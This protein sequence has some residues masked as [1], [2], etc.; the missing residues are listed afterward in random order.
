LRGE[1][2][3]AKECPC[4]YEPMLAVL[5]EEEHGGHAGEYFNAAG[6]CLQEEGGAR[7]ASSTEGCQVFEG[8][9]TSGKRLANKNCVRKEV[10][11]GPGEG[12]KGTFFTGAWQCSTA[13]WKEKEKRREEESGSIKP[14]RPGEGGQGIVQ[15]SS[16]PLGPFWGKKKRLKGFVPVGEGGSTVPAQ[17]T[18]GEFRSPAGEGDSRG[19]WREE[20]TGNTGTT[21]R[22]GKNAT[23]RYL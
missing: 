4:C 21:A 22:I 11:A 13:A 19:V 14:N 10:S 5:G 3:V 6:L 2:D 23:T 12:N 15:R 16:F 18:E 20:G 8:K 17:Q 7:V 9:D 1:G